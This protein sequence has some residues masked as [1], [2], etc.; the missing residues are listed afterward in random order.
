MWNG[1][2]YDGKTADRQPVAVTIVGDGL[3]IHRPDGSITVWPIG[4]IR[5]TQGAFSSEPL[6]LERGTNPVEAVLVMQQGLPAAIRQAFPDTRTT[7]R[8][9]RSTA[10]RIAWAS[11]IVATSIVLYIW[12]AP[13][14]AGWLATRVPPDWEV[15]LGREVAER[16]APASRQCGDS[17]SLAQLRLVMD[18]LVLAASENRYEFHLVVLRDTTV[19]AFALPGGFI[20]VH[21]GLLEAS[22]T[23]DQ[24]AGVLAHEMQHVLHRH[25][26]RAI[27]REVPLRVVISAVAGG[28]GLE[29]A[30]SVAGSLSALRY[31]RADELEADREGI[32][33]LET[34]RVNPMGVVEIMRLLQ[35]KGGNGPRFASYLTSH[36]QTALRV[37]ELESLARASRVAPAPVMDA[38]AWQ[39][40]RRMCVAAN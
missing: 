18:R 15:S 19:N 25:S 32:R 4:E 40:V 14:F 6:R 29:R 38:A 30:A 7:V 37:S 3:A 35:K 21:Q 17:A 13:L 1:F 10:R 20:A 34:A 24:F 28:S 27:I 33:L 26:T 36:P 8:G 11:T 5:Q 22:E 12:L 23:P 39:R 16:M 2:Y 9:S 31:R